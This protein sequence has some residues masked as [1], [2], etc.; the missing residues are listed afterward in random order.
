M[1]NRTRGA[2][3]QPGGAENEPLI[4]V[5]KGLRQILLYR[6]NGDRSARED[7][8]EEIDSVIQSG[9]KGVSRSKLSEVIDQTLEVLAG[10]LEDSAERESKSKDSS[11]VG[12]LWFVGKLLEK[13]Y[14]SITDVEHAQFFIKEIS[15][16]IDQFVAERDHGVLFEKEKISAKAEECF[17]DMEARKVAY[18]AESGREL[19]ESR[20]RVSLRES[21]LERAIS[22]LEESKKYEKILKES[23]LK[24]LK[25]D[26]KAK[27][28]N[29]LPKSLENEPFFVEFRS[30]ISGLPKK[31]QK[32]NLIENDQEPKG[33]V[34]I[35][36]DQQKQE[37]DQLSRLLKK[38]EKSV[39]S[40]HDSQDQIRL[41]AEKDN[42]IRE[43]Q[44]KLKTMNE[45]IS[46]LNVI[47]ERQKQEAKL[48]L[49][50]KEDEHRSRKEEMER[51]KSMI[52]EA[53]TKLAV[54]NSE[55]IAQTQRIRMLTEDSARLRS[56][57]I[58][59]KESI[60]ELY[61]KIE[62]KS[63]EIH[64]LVKY[65]EKAELLRE[66]NSRLSKS[67]DR[68]EGDLSQ[69][70]GELKR[71]RERLKL[72]LQQNDE[73]LNE[74]LFFEAKSE[75][76]ETRLTELAYH[77]T[78]NRMEE[79]ERLKGEVAKLRSQNRKLERSVNPH[80]PLNE[81]LRKS[82]EREEDERFISS[83][84]KSTRSK[85]VREQFERKILPFSD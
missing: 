85:A 11:S 45:E 44:S 47:L 79:N 74:K 75:R 27:N 53:E 71:L 6:R 81:T 5:L 4:R 23:I 19:A 46:S 20:P 25:Q 1:N 36:Q 28:D 37:I 83:H 7:M 42:V 33:R 59:D 73:L 21:E 34:E 64:E 22:A 68:R 9:D 67:R 78:P 52:S 76:L 10:I 56:T 58:A 13:S 32:S 82:V 31:S 43:L 62:R 57:A 72:L 3:K 30:L 35:L 8:I 16:K 70:H 39:P 14:I 69:F 60:K 54:K 61:E 50:E 41:L 40:V 17:T 12:H 48:E 38:L 15:L 84:Q 24:L 80:S 2:S 26:D 18:F 77:S 55:M 66:E 49:I 65:K 63:A 29:T 51:L